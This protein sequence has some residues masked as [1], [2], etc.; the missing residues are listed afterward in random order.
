MGRQ[1]DARVRHA[2]RDPLHRSLAQALAVRLIETASD[3][4]SPSNVRSAHKLSARQMRILTDYIEG[5]LDQKLS[6][7]D[8]A[9]I[10]GVG[11]HRHPGV[12]TGAGR[13]QWHGTIAAA[14]VLAT[15]VGACS[16]LLPLQAQGINDVGGYH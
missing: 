14:A 12:P 3:S 5:N 6:L 16:L 8:L 11:R 4:S 1:G 7:A 9:E 13:K 10:A 15:V 2:I